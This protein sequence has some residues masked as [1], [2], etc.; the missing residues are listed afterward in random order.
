MKKRSLFFVVLIIILFFGCDNEPP[1][2]DST[3]E[4]TFHL[5]LEAVRKNMD[6]EGFDKITSG[7]VRLIA[8]P[9]SLLQL[10]EH[11]RRYEYDGDK[12]PY[13]M[14]L[15]DGKTGPQVIATIEKYDTLMFEAE[16]AEMLPKIK[17]LEKHRDKKLF[18]DKKLSK[19]KFLKSS[20][21]WRKG[22]FGNEQALSI[23]VKNNLDIA[24]TKA[25]IR[26]EF[27]SPD[28]QKKCAKGL[29]TSLE[30]EPP[31]ASGKTRTVTAKRRIRDTVQDNADIDIKL[32]KIW[33]NDT[34]Y[35]RLSFD[36]DQV[37]SLKSLKKKY[38]VD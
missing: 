34:Y 36:E 27:Y 29:G 1:K 37:A 22:P 11:Q 19:L 6:Q 12:K 13:L 23:T 38:N 20:V 4:E 28:T 25:R 16:K 9:Y 14:K 30:F 35:F 7:V 32:Y 33:G 24:I 10:Y 8:Q 17:K 3:N 21:I 2:I 31:L 26:A 15:L 18:M 5:T